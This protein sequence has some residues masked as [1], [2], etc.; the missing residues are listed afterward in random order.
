[1]HTFLAIVLLFFVFSFFGWCME[2]LT[3]LVAYGENADRGFLHLPFCTIYGGALALIRLLLGVPLSKE[4]AYPWNMLSL[5]GYAVGAALAATAAELTVGAFFYETYG[6][7]L[8]TYRGYPHEFRGYI[9]LPMSVAWGGL[10]TVAMAVLWK[11]MERA[12]KRLPVVV[13]AAVDCFLAAALTADFFICL[14]VA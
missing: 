2:K 12:V 11:P 7:R 9:C 1:M 10:I 14:A 3:F 13:L 6:L 4:R 8:W 5:I